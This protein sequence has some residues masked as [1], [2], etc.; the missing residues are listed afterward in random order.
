[1]P[2]V[3]SLPDLE[4]GERLLCR[5]QFVRVYPT[6]LRYRNRKIFSWGCEN[7]HVPFWFSASRLVMAHEPITGNRPFLECLKTDGSS[8]GD[9]FT[10]ICFA[11]AAPVIDV[12]S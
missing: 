6:R 3:V 7:F 1:M 2:T 11:R 8:G 10:Y 12:T 9:G 5:R 4:K